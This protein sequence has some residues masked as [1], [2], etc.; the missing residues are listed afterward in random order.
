MFFLPPP[1]PRFAIGLFSLAL[2]AACCG[3][4]THWVVTW[5]ASPSP[6]LA[7]EAQ[8]A[9]QHLLFNSQTLCEIV[10]V[11][12]GGSEVRVRFSNAFGPQPIQIGAASIAARGASPTPVTFAGRPFMVIPPNAVAISDPINLRVEP[13]SDLSIRIYLPGPVKGAG[14]HYAAMQTSFVGAGD[15]TANGVEPEAGTKISSWAF[16]AGVDVQAPLS[17]SAVALFG[18]SITDGAHSTPNANHRWPDVLAERLLARHDAP[19]VGVLNEGIGGNRILHDAAA[20]VAFGV[21]ALA[22]FDRDVLAQPGLRFLVVMEGINDIG[23]PGTS[24]APLSDAIT[25]ED[26]IGGLSQLIER[27]HERGLK[28]F[29]ATLTPFEGAAHSYFNPEKETIR[30]KYNSW[31]RRTPLLDGVIDFDR[32]TQDPAHP[33]RFLPAYDSG[34]HLH[35]NDAG[36]RAMGEAVDL[37]FFTEKARAL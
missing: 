35:P 10:H 6:Q 25:A 17:T 30:Q 2:T 19:P 27:A 9:K 12:L 13:G 29:A 37:R 26:L 16:L 4:P 36:Y 22:R 8:L 28:I 5:G 23:H 1:L 7:D 20:N 32:V 18:D 14:I 15:L 3:Q 24:S 33:L 21:S 34:D 31:I 11:S